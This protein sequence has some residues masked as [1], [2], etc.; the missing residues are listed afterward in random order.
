MPRYEIEGTQFTVDIEKEELKQ[1]DNPKNTIPFE[2][3]VI[4][5]GELSFFYDKV[6]KIVSPI[7]EDGRTI[8]VVLPQRTL[9]DPVGMSEKYDVPLDDIRSKTDYEVMVDEDLVKKRLSGFQPV[10]D[11]AGH[12][13]FVNIK[14]R[15]LNPKDDPTT[16]IDL[17]QLSESRD[18]ERYRF[19]Y[20]PKER[21]VIEVDPGIT[22]IPTNLL[23]LE[24][25]AD[26]RLDPVG[27]ARNEGMGEVEMKD[28]LLRYPI[29]KGLKAAVIPMSDTAL[30][31]IV[32]ANRLK[33][34]APPSDPKPRKSLKKKNRHKR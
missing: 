27:M 20:D 15:Y 6:E 3:M 4:H 24:I 30:P 12:P 7:W 5:N 25:P 21:K 28:W 2:Q 29:Q 13:F 17:R 8:E 14:F 9:L 16:F 34:V 23:V 33:K 18:G 10:I 26:H 1:V 22:E 32:E 31:E 19:F 11:I